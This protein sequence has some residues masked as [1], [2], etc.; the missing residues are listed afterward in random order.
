VPM[1]VWPRGVLIGCLLWSLVA[2]AQVT[3]PPDTRADREVAALIQVVARSGCL[4][5]R[6]GRWNAA[7]SAAAHLRRKNEVIRLRAGDLYSAELFIE[8]AASESS[9][10]GL[11]YRVRCPGQPEQLSRD[12]LMARLDRFRDAAR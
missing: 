4:F 6:N 1:T 2:T 12:W 10:T 8:R 3:T 7:Q 5:Q 11:P 9:L